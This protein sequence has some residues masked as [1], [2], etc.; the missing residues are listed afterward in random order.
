MSFL[1]SLENNLKALESRDEADP[2]ALARQQAERMGDRERARLTAPHA[3][4]LRSS[5]F[6][7]QLLSACRQMGHPSRTLVRPTWLD[8]TLR[9]DA[10]D[11]RLEFQPG[12]SGILAVFFEGGVETGIET[13]D[14]SGGAK[15]FAERL[16]RGF[17]KPE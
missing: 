3:E 11:R 5:P 13:V 6:V 1:D 8:S 14:L 15:S 10:R 12:P 7:G 2:A 9:L 16:L 17:V 4:A